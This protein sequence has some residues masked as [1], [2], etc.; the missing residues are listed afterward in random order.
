MK[1]CSILLTIREMQIKTV[2]YH[3]TFVKMPIIKSQEM[4]SVGKDVKEREHLFID[5]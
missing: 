1:K 5:K 4:K 2:I 3:L